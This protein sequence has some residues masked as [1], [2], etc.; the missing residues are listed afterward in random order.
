MAEDPKPSTSKSPVEES[1][2]APNPP[3]RLPQHI[4]TMIERKMELRKRWQQTRC[5][6][7]RNEIDQLNA[8]I[9]SKIDEVKDDTWFMY[10]T[11]R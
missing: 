7:T 11:K 2:R 3:M 4:M 1:P 8:K 5:P 6:N 9:S 10:Q